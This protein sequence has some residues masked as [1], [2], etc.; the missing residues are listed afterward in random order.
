MEQVAER[1]E[2]WEATGLID[3]ATASR[4]RLAEA[5][6]SAEPTAAAQSQTGRSSAGHASPRRGPTS[7]ASIFGPG[8]TIGEMF[9]YLGGTFLLGAYET[10]VFRPASVDGPQY[11]A[12]TTGPAAAAVALA[13]FG[14]YLR[15]GDA[16]RRRAA[17]VM[18]ALAVLHVGVA[19]ASLGSMASLGWPAVGVVGAAVATVAAIGVRLLHPALLTQVALLASITSFA[20]LSISWLQAVAFPPQDFDISGQLALQAGPNPLIL[21]AISAAW[22]LALAVIIGLIGLREAGMADDDAVAGRRAAVT[23][24]WAGLVA[25]IGLASAVTRSSYDSAAGYARAI[26]PWVGDL[27]I[28]LLAAILV[29]R[30]FRRDAS[31]YV[32]AAALGLMIALTDFNF[33]YLSSSTDVGLLIE[34]IILLVAGI[35]AD[36]LRRRI[37]RVEPAPTAQIATG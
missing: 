13:L 5:E 9:A 10:F 4:L 37:G 22:W 32:Y 34:G 3:P 15:S 35:G 17:G 14:L 28:I 8:V 23:R 30:A 29:E 26:E 2:A 33:T 7:M 12:M 19:G 24:L 21:V 1:I 6:R 27:A 16:R 31:T 20:G 11:L 25:V 36:R 18:F